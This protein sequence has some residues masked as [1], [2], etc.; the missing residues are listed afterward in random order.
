MLLDIVLRVLID[1][2]NNTI[3]TGNTYATIMFSQRDQHNYNRK[4][5]LEFKHYFDHD[6]SLMR[7]VNVK[8]KG[9]WKLIFKTQLTLNKLI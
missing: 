1:F 8:S 9:W 4:V 7:N 5:Y 2:N 3:E 6:H